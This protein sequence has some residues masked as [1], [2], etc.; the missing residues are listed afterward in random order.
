MERKTQPLKSLPEQKENP[1]SQPLLAQIL[2]RQSPSFCLELGEHQDASGGQAGRQGGRG[3]SGRQE[4]PG[5]CTA[6]RLWGGGAVPA[7][8]PWQQ[9]NWK[10]KVRSGTRSWRKWGGGCRVLAQQW[11]LTA[12]LQRGWGGEAT[13]QEFAP[14]ESL[15][16]RQGVLRPN[17]QPSEHGG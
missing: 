13:A 1:E 12:C 2:Q 8:L 17:A 5:G 14:A 11:K 15:L 9:H 16:A 6:Q 4:P 3:G 7:S 10:R